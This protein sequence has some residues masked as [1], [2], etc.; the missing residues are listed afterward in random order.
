MHWAAN[1]L[2]AKVGRVM[3]EYGRVCH[4]GKPLQRSVTLVHDTSGIDIHQKEEDCGMRRQRSN[5]FQDVCERLIIVPDE[6][7]PVC[8]RW[9]LLAKFFQ[10]KSFIRRIAHHHGDGFGVRQNA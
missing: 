4:G 9:K 2:A 3:G 7:K 10:P 5:V 6:R 1:N 8:K